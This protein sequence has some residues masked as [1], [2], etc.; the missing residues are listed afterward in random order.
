MPEIGQDVGRTRQLEGEVAVA[1]RHLVTGLRHGHV[2]GHRGGHDDHVRRISP[3]E[4]RLVHLD[5]AAHADHLA[6]RRFVQARRAGHQRDLR[7]APHRLLGNREAHAAARSVA[8]VAHRIEVLVGRSGRHQH[9]LSLERGRGPQDRLGAGHDVF[10]LGQPPFSDPA[11]RE[12]TLA[13]IHESH[14]AAR[15]RLDIPADG[16]MVEHLAV[17]RGG[18]Q[19]RRPRGRVERGQEIVGEPVGQFADDVRGGRGDEQQVDRGR[20]GDVLDVG[21]GSRLELAGDDATARDRLERQGA[22]EIGGGGRHDRHDVVSALLQPA[23]DLDR[24]VG[25]DAACDTKRYQHGCA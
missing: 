6:V 16:L 3:G 13:R 22:D 17:H 14:A 23:R 18:E 9:P 24:L 12:V 2:V 11:A 21:V 7:P 1:L 19:H 10:G 15:E 8:D 20:E 5:R 4:D 25:A